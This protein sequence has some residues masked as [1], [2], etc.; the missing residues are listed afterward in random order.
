MPDSWNA[1]LRAAVDRGTSFLRAQL[2]AGRYAMSVRGSDETSR[3]SHQ[4]GHV[5]VGFFVAEALQ[6]RLT[7]IERTILL[8]RILSEER[9]GTWGFSPADLYVTPA[10]ESFLVDADDSAYVLRTLRM[11][12]AFRPPIG[13]LEFIRTPPGGFVTFVGKGG[14]DNRLEFATEPSFENNLA[15]H[16]EVNFNAFLMLKQTS[17]ERHINFDVIE[18]WQRVDGSW[19]AYFYPS[20]YFAC[21]MAVE[22][23]TSMEYYQPH[24]ERTLAFI[25]QA[26]NADGSWG[27]S[28]N[29]YE[30]ALALKTLA[31]G[32]RFGAEYRRGVDYLLSTQ[33][34]DESWRTSGVIWEYHDRGSDVWRAFD[35]D[36]T[37]TTALVVTALR[38]F[39]IE[40]K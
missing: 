17:W 33:G 7:E 40:Q 5:F 22:F 16:P 35:E 24:V 9:A 8:V 15:L 31:A 10:H 21:P 20:P 30:T 26:Q 27:A 38:A 37:L 3:F 12:G 39:P 6:G 28:G 23:L 11:L 29:P 2:H 32:G 1:A 19:P 18:P 4:K 14:L 34:S 25:A 13:L 36:R